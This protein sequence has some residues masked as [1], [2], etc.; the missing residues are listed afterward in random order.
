MG[1]TLKAIHFEPIEHNVLS[2]GL[3]NEAF[4]LQPYPLN[5]QN[6]EIFV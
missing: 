5:L 2:N 3:K 4:T 1:T 6:F